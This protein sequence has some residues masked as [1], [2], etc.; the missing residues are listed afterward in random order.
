MITDNEISLWV[1]D[2]LSDARKV[3]AYFEFKL[4]AEKIPCKNENSPFSRALLERG[5]SLQ[6]REEVLDHIRTCVLSL[7]TDEL[8]GA[9]PRHAVVYVFSVIRTAQ[10][11]NGSL[12]VKGLS[13]ADMHSGYQALVSRE[14]M[15]ALNSGRGS[16]AGMTA[17]LRPYDGSFLHQNR[18]LYR[19]LI[20][21]TGD[22]AKG[23][24]LVENADC[25]YEDLSS[26]E[27]WRLNDLYHHSTNG[28]TPHIYIHV[29]S[30][31]T[32]AANSVAH[33]S[34]VLEEG[35]D[36][37]RFNEFLTGYMKNLPEFG[38]YIDAI[39]EG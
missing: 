4:L 20:E 7:T 13:L 18:L 32:E 3:S 36:L 35:E 39:L 8:A 9:L 2:I 25:I 10:K 19:D 21:F 6:S 15:Y 12:F 26:F 37:E 34:I 38:D 11:K 29:A 24:A 30:N 17:I 1:A 31:S 33:W 16:P 28:G 23:L 5:F 14:P 27:Q 22:R